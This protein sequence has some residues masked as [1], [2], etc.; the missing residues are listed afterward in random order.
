MNA[1]PTEPF[2]GLARFEDTDVDAALFFGRGR[3]REIVAANLMA[4]RLTV[5]YGESGVGKSSL[6]RAGVAHHLRRS[7][8]PLIVVVFDAWQSDPVETLVRALADAAGIEPAATLADTLDACAAVV[9]GDVYVLLDQVDEYFLYHRREA[10]PETFAE[11]FPAAVGRPGSRAS[12]LVALREE[13]LAKLDSFKGRIPNLFGNYLRLEHLDRRAARAAILGPV[14]HV[15]QGAPPDERV[16]LEPELVEAV[17]DEVAA[18]KLDL[19]Q[20]GRGVVG[21]AAADGRIETP[22]LQLVMQRLWEAEREAGSRTLRL[23]TLRALGGAEQIVRDQLRG[24]LDALGAEQQDLAAAVFNHLVTP[25]GTKIAHGV[26]DLAEYARVD[27]GALA[28]VL[29]GLAAERILRPVADESGGERYEIY[30]DVL[31]DA[32]LAWKRAHDV[33]RELERQR[34]AATRRHRRLVGALVAAGLLLAAMVAVTVFALTQRGNARTQARLA[35]A[36]ELAATAASELQVDPQASLVLGVES[37]RLARTSQA[38]DVLR[39]AL[40]ES[41]ERAI[42]PSR[43]PVRTVSFSPD[44]SLVLTAGDDGTARLWHADDGRPVAVLRQGG[45]LTGASFSPDGRLILTTSDDGTARLWR[46]GGEVV[47]TLHHS[48]PVTS[49]SFSRDGTRVLTTSRDGTARLW[50]VEG[51]PLLTVEHG[52][53]LLGGSISPDGRLLVTVSSDRTGQALRARLFALPSGRLIRQLPAKGVT[54]ASFDPTGTRL[55]TGG[56]D[57]TAAIWEV[58]GGRLL[59]LFSEQQGGITD[60]LFGP[61]GRLAVTTSSDGTTRIWDARTGISRTL[62]MGHSN[63]VNSAAFSADGALLVTTSFDGTA[64]VWES[65]TGELDAVLRGHADSVLA[66]AFSPDGRTVATASA[67]G[68][69]RLWAAGIPRL[70]VLAAGK[71]AVRTARF[72]PDDRLVLAAGDDGVTRI[73]TADGKLLHSLRQHEP[74]TSA[75]FTRDGRLV[76]TTDAAG[77]VRVW[78]T[79]TGE[80]VRAVPKLSAGPLALSPDGRLLA[81]PAASGGLCVWGATSFRLLRELRRGAPFT[82]ASFSPDGRLLATAGEDGTARL[83]DVGRGAL[84]RTLS[85]HTD[86]LTDVQFSPDG[87]LLVTASRDHDARIWAVATGKM[88]RLLRGHFGPVFGAAFSPDGRWVVTAGPI[89]TGLWPVSTGWLLFF[90]RGPKQP[91][92]SASFSADGTRILASSRDGTVRTYTCE[93]CGN[94]SGLL[95]TATARLARLSAP[96]GPA[97]RARY[98]PT[99]VPGTT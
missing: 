89:T 20:A 17:L 2:K 74:V 12:F 62:L 58:P 33:D 40:I 35:H 28:P 68:T 82:A 77:T 31:A 75:L 41:R 76:L 86:A 64:R 37:A 45:H 15:N 78:R 81:G 84:V 55:I 10:G 66:A 4:S 93:L 19:A 23:S 34:Q 67:D 22:Y 1:E 18:G 73:L 5:L 51:K 71:A 7:P 88:V 6:L 50:T 96:L 53:P 59:H 3:D 14:E 92:T 95:A 38:E 85:A 8:E 26:A 24:A 9:G 94:L 79:A 63:I 42:L 48:G 52:R 39:R 69:A 80:L 91:L 11:Q 47:A 56:I 65:D 87:T 60:A 21:M 49:G 98:L 13:S 43:G 25:S 99:A 90:V 30:H 16:E 44:G 29:A 83:W 32:A 46:T 36:R 70:G 72:S 97:D 54:V 57:H 61:R 27:E